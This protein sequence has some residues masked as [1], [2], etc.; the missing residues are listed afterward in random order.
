MEHEE[1]KIR[2]LFTRAAVGYRL[3]RKRA[4]STYFLIHGFP[5]PDEKRDYAGRHTYRI[6]KYWYALEKQSLEETGGAGDGP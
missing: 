5:P 6:G 1:E 2:V 3:I 4:D